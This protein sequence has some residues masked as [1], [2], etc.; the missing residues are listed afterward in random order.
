[1]PL[2]RILALLAI[3]VLLPLSGHADQGFPYDGVQVIDCQ[4]NFKTL[5]NDLDAAVR[6]HRMG[7]VGRASASMGG[8]PAGHRDTGQCRLWRLPQ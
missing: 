8:R 4:K 5:F 2:L 1:M 7:V 3:L 6:K